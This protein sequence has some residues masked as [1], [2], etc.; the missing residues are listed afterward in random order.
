MLEFW[1]CSMR[2]GLKNSCRVLSSMVASLFFRLFGSTQY[3][4][5]GHL[6][7]PVTTRGERAYRG[8]ALWC[9]WLGYHQHRPRSHSAALTSTVLMP[10]YI[11][12]VRCLSM[13]PWRPGTPQVSWPP[14]ARAIVIKSRRMLHLAPLNSLPSRTWHQHYGFLCVLYAIKVSMVSLLGSM[15]SFGVKNVWSKPCQT[16]TRRSCLICITMPSLQLDHTHRSSGR[17]SSRSSNFMTIGK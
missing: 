15:G 17:A 8:D 4:W 3:A 14:R 6:I 13:E 5:Y 1:V 7:C 16:N 9:E 11:S 2:S 12:S 10:H